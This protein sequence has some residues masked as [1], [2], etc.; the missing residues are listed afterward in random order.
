MAIAAGVPFLLTVM[1]GKRKMT[2]PETS[3]K[4][5]GEWTAF[6]GGEVIELKEVGDGVFSEGIMGEGLASCRKTTLFMRRQK[7]LYRY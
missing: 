6:L 4:G 2:A 1:A 5:A 3:G 7:A